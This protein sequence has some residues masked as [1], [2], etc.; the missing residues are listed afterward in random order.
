MVGPPPSPPPLRAR[1]E[2][3][4]FGRA[5]E[6]FAEELPGRMGRRPPPLQSLLAPLSLSENVTM[7]EK[8]GGKETR[9]GSFH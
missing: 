5:E 9:K 6:L 4:S 2:K 3:T 7:T 8:E 1:S